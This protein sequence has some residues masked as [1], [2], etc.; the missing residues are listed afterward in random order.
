MG[1]KANRLA[2]DK[3]FKKYMMEILLVIMAIILSVS[4]H[5]ILYT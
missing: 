2:L 5:G 1:S 3:I 4:A